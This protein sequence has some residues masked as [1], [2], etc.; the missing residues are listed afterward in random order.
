MSLQDHFPPAY[1]LGLEKTGPPLGQ[2]NRATLKNLYRR[3]P[4]GAPPTCVNVIEKILQLG[5]TE[6]AHAASLDF[7]GRMM[8]R[9]I[10]PKQDAV[11]IGLSYVGHFL[12]PE[13]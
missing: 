12:R 3:T 1:L 13:Y 7:Y 6:P 10:R 5:F 8:E 2:L 11:G 9:S 4:K